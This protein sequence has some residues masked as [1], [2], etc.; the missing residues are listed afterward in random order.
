[1]KVDSRPCSVRR[2]SKDHAFGELDHICKQCWSLNESKLR[3]PLRAGHQDQPAEGN[4]NINTVLFLYSQCKYWLNNHYFQFCLHTLYLLVQINPF[5]VVPEVKKQISSNFGGCK[6]PSAKGHGSSFVI[7]EGH[8]LHLTCW[9][10]MFGRCVVA[11]CLL[12]PS[13]ILPLQ[14]CIRNCLDHSLLCSWKK[15]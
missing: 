9:E 14:H 7:S 5:Q 4:V 8:R 12:F 15:V 6:N 3:D 1:M 13:G 10:G 11:Q 2:V